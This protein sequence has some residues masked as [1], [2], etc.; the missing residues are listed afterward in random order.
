[1]GSFHFCYPVVERA[2]AKSE[3]GEEQFQAS[4]LPE[5]LK[6][7]GPNL[8][9]AVR[10]PT[11]LEAKHGKALPPMEVRGLL[12]TGAAHTSIDT[13]LAE[14]LALTSIGKNGIRTASSGKCK[15]P[16]LWFAVD[17][18]FTGS[19]LQS[20]K[21]LHVSSCT[22]GFDLTKHRKNPRDQENIGILIGR[23]V[24]SRWHITWDGPRSTVF[25]YD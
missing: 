12:D 19:T 1:M 24:M 6:T 25:I 13:K 5:C 2:G 21:D 9:V 7:L 23:D 20:V 16:S 8:P 11:K 10:Q 15:L 18:D 14:A 3:E 17:L 22:I 4:F